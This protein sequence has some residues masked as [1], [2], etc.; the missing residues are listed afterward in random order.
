MDV[1]IALLE[2]ATAASTE[3]HLGKGDFRVSWGKQS[4]P[5]P[6]VP[7]NESWQDRA[8]GN[9]RLNGELIKHRIYI[10][11]LHLLHIKPSCIQKIMADAKQECRIE[12]ACPGEQAR[13]Q[14]PK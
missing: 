8:V 7:A 6:R 5:S 2:E 13:C 3:M 9:N 4:E 11:H 10:V 1:L 14:L 12:Q